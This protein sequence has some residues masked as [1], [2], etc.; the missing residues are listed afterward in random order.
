[1][2]VYQEMWIRKHRGEQVVL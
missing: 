1:M 2:A